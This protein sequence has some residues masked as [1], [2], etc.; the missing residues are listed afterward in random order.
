MV[1]TDDDIAGRL[2][3]PPAGRV[4]EER[5]LDVDPKNTAYRDCVKN[6]RPAGYAGKLGY[7]SAGAG[8]DFIVVN[9]VAEA[10]ERQ[11]DAE[12]SR[13]ARPE[14]GR[15]VLQGLMSRTP[16]GRP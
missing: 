11:Q 8:A 10:D 4:L 7:A 15:A 2:H 13:R 6:M 9:M 1:L 3:R 14:A 16:F 5:G 12:G